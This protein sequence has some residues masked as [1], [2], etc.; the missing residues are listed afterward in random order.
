MISEELD[1]LSMN[2]YS[3][4]E[5]NLFLPVFQSINRRTGFKDNA[6]RKI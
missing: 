1:R 6:S 4:K 2:M 5:R 3:V